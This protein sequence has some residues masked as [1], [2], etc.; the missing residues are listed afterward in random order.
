VFR[1]NEEGEHDLLIIDYVVQMA[2]SAYVLEKDHRAGVEPPRL[3][4]GHFDSDCTSYNDCELPRW[5]RVPA[6]SHR[7]W[8]RRDQPKTPDRHRACR[9][10]IR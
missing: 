1:H 2:S 9:P 7:L 6:A 10:H 8:R 3:A 4:I 5:G